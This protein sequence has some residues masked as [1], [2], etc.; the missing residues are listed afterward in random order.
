MQEILS[1]NQNFNNIMFHAIKVEK[2][3][4]FEDL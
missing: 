4:T 3:P 2:Q 1:T